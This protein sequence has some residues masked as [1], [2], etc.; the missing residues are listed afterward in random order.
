MVGLQPNVLLVE[1]EQRLA[2]N[3]LRAG[4]ALVTGA[5]QCHLREKALN[6]RRCGRDSEDTACDLRQHSK[7]LNTFLSRHSEGKSRN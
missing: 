7:L 6:G 3:G 5:M 2:T 1:V 4:L